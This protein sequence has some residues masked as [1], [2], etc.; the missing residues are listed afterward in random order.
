[1]YDLVLIFFKL[2]Y[3]YLKFCK[4][5]TAEP[6]STMWPILLATLYNVLGKYGEAY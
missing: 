1:M 5:E 3:G 4:W 6:V 2:Q